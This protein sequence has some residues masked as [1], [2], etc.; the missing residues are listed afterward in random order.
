[1]KRFRLERPEWNRD[2]YTYYSE[3]PEV[4]Y[5]S[6]SYCGSDDLLESSVSQYV[7][8]DSYGLYSHHSLSGSG[9]LTDDLLNTF[10]MT[11]YSKLDY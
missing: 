9:D 1:M 3:I 8:P 4:Q 11:G 6:K 5:H 2:C 10:S 7:Y